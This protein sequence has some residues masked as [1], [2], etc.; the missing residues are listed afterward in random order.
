M[1]GIVVKGESAVNQAPITGE[2]IPV[3]KSPI[4]EPIRLTKASERSNPRVNAR[5]RVFAG[6]INGAGAL[7]IKVTKL[8]TDSTLARVITW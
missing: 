3:D 7:E 1:D 2:S 6:T 8:S 5:H 4:A